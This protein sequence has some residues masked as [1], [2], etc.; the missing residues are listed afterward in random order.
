MKL[1]LYSIESF[2]IDLPSQI[3]LECKSG[4]VDDCNLS[5]SMEVLPFTCRSEMIFS[6]NENDA[7]GT[8]CDNSQSRQNHTR[9][10]WTQ[11]VRYEY[12][13]RTSLENNFFLA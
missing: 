6:T 5:L 7:C 10:G 12:N 3:G 13:R 1:K 11:F 9:R 2:R 4:N 8:K